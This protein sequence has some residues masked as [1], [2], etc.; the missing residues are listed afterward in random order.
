MVD[1]QCR[2][3]DDTPELQFRY[4]FFQQE[5]R[6]ARQHHQA[7]AKAQS[8]AGGG[9]GKTQQNNSGSRPPMVQLDAQTGQPTGVL[10]ERCLFA[11]EHI[12][13]KHAYSAEQVDRLFARGLWECMRRG[14]TVRFVLSFAG[15]HA[16]YI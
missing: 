3:A 6:Y 8:A 7:R 2:L 16:Y 5:L 1:T 14:L 13:Y 11:L 12:L 10:T 9:G 15:Q 4:H